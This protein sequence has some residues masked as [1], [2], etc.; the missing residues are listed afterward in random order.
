MGRSFA[1]IAALL[2]SAALA[3]C[4]GGEPS[5][6]PAPEPAAAEPP[7][8]DRRE[9]V[10]ALL[11]DALAGRSPAREA[12]VPAGYRLR[13]ARSDHVALAFPPGWQALTSRDARFPGVGQMFAR[14]DPRLGSAVAAL[15]AV[16]GPMKLLGFDRRGQAGFATTASVMLGR[17][18][19]G[20][21]YEEWSVDAVRRV[22]DLPSVQGRVLKRKVELP[23]GEALRLEFVRA[24]A[25]GSRIATLQYLVVRGETL[26]IVTY[27]TRPGLVARYARAFAASARTLR[28]V[29]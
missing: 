12:P 7:A 19:P 22:R 23:L 16:D 18:R 6:T 26:Y 8:T 9:A 28:R 13:L 15:G 25:G 2:A 14:L 3:G 4:A 17:V 24:Y 20:V 29:D 27:A 1:M 10:Q 11:G 21:A 5:A